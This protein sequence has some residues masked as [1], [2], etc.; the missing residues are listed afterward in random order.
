[1]TNAVHADFE[2]NSTVAKIHY[3]LSVFYPIKMAILYRFGAPADFVLECQ[4][5]LMV[6]HVLA[7]N[8]AASGSTWG[9]RLSMAVGIFMLILIPIGTIVGAFVVHFSR[10]SKWESP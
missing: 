3:W 8:G 4:A 6:V 7:M 5:V 2:K 9:R 1:M 10:Q